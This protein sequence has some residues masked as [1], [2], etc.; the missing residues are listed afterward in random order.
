MNLERSTN[1]LLLNAVEC[2]LHYFSNTTEY[3]EAYYK[4]R[5]EYR[6]L[7]EKEAA[8]V[9]EDEPTPSRITRTRTSKSK[10]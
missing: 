2:W 10:S 5:D 9:V 8:P 6:A 4:L 1:W 3:T 7:V